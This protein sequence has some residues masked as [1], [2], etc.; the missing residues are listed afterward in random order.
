MD[1]QSD[2]MALSGFTLP[3]QF[4]AVLLRALDELMGTNGLKALLNAAG[5]SEWINDPPPDNDQRGVDFAHLSNLMQALV[6]LYGEKGAQSLMRPANSKVFEQLWANN[7]HF[8]LTQHE[9]FLKLDAIEKIQ[10]GMDAFASVLSETSDLASH[11]ARHDAS[12]SFTLE[13]C[14]YCWGVESESARCSAFIGLL[15]SAAKKFAPDSSIMIVES[16]CGCGGSNNCVFEIKLI[17]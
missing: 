2:L 10:T 17:S 12:I 4:V 5:Q 14:P 8:D 1:K 3:N 16:S 6:D 7:P 11:S 9:E 13:K 15:E